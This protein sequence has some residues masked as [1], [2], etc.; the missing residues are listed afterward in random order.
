M[1]PLHA[2][3]TLFA[4]AL[5][6][7]IA[8]AQRA[9]L[10]GTVR[11]SSGA[12]VS[13][14]E[15]ILSQERRRVVT[16][17]LGRYVVGDLPRRT[18]LVR[19]RRLGYGPQLREVD[20]SRG[21]ATFGIVVERVPFTLAPQVVSASR[22][23][24]TGVVGDTSYR[25]IADAE[26]RLIGYGRE[27]RTDATGAFAFDVPAGQYQVRV[28]RIYY[29]QKMFSVTVPK[30][31]GRHV[32]VW[33]VPFDST[34]PKPFLAMMGGFDGRQE[35]RMTALARRT[36][37]R[38]LPARYFGRDELERS[39]AEWVIDLVPRLGVGVP[40]ATDVCVILNGG[41]QV[42]YADM[43]AVSEL[44]AVEIYPP[45]SLRGM[46]VA[47]YD[48]TSIVGGSRS[49]FDARLGG[50]RGRLAVSGD[51]GNYHTARCG[52][53]RVFAWSR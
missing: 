8:R 40:M 6:P 2:I 26:V 20:L 4:I 32:T 9:T 44:D 14:V 15:V 11:D 5:L 17:S 49:S 27:T 38:T 53:W 21:D 10:R 31:S 1:R 46:S 25:A 47:D 30:D 22:G 41:P 51:D 34:L 19:F 45:G 35:L 36:A 16:D 50:N 18:V 28:R 23:G 24:L 37:R 3:L 13:G 7:E 12:P 52:A 43:V 39:G 29:G 48:A 33:L 42:T